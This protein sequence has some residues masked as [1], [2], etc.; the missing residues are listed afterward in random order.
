MRVLDAYFLRPVF[1]KLS[2]KVVR[3]YEGL[4]IG[5]MVRSYS[6]FDLAAEYVA[7]ILRAFSLDSLNS[8][9]TRRRGKTLKVA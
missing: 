9:T 7:F 3:G 6:E 1:L 5:K 2:Q 8:G 4:R